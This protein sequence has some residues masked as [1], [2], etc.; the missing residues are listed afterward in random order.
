MS[1][2]LAL[3]GSAARGLSGLASDSAGR[4]GQSS[5]LE[6]E[7]NFD[8]VDV[9]RRWGRTRVALAQAIQAAHGG[10][11]RAFADTQG[12]EV[13]GQDFIDRQVI[14]YRTGESI[15]PKV[16]AI[17]GLLSPGGARPGGPV[18]GHGPTVLDLA[19]PVVAQAGQ[20]SRTAIP[21]S[22]GCQTPYVELD[23][24]T[25]EVPD[26]AN[27]STCKSIVRRAILGSRRGV[28]PFDLLRSAPE[29]A[30]YPA[31]CDPTMC[32]APT[33]NVRSLGRKL[34]SHRT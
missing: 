22:T 21:S 5:G 17:R 20:S 10:A 11:L 3:R 23:T 6:R 30:L 9:S 8:G 13:S 1:R 12:E 15:P 26:L 34:V 16:P 29:K 27:A 4:G 33:N 2:T 24:Q 14:S 7:L 32:P 19:A 28:F 25:G 31:A 18:G